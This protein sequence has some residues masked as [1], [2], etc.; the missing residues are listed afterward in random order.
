MLPSRRDRKFSARTDELLAAV[1]TG[2][3]L[4]KAARAAGATKWAT[5]ARTLEADVC[6]T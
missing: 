4:S 6:A 2:T 1:R 5:L 3:Q